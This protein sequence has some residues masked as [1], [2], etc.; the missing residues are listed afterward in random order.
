M[1]NLNQVNISEEKTDKVQKSKFKSTKKIPPSKP[2]SASITKISRL[3][4]DAS[5]QFSARQ[6]NFITNSRYDTTHT[7][8]LMSPIEAQRKNARLY[9]S[10]DNIALRKKRRPTRHLSIKSSPIVPTAPKDAVTIKKN[11]LVTQARL[12]IEQLDKPIIIATLLMCFLGLIFINSATHSFE[13]VRFVLIQSA[14]CILG[15][16]LMTV[17]SYIDYRQIIKHYRTIIAINAA[18]LLLT[19]IF[20]SSVTETSNANWIDLGIIKIQPSEFSKLLFIYTFSVHISYVKERLNKFST[21]ITLFIHACLIF[22]LVLLQK[23]LGSLTIFLMIF[24]AM[25]FASGLSIWYYILGGTLA[26]GLSPFIWERLST[27]Q[28]D[29]ILLCF[30]KS[31]D[32]NGTGIRYQQLRSS[33]AIG[34]GGIHGTGYMQGSLT[35]SQG[36]SLPAKHTDMI[37]STVCEEWG[38]IGAII[39][40]ALACYL[41]WRIV[42]LALNCEH[43]AGQ[44]ICVGVAWM[45][46][47]QIIENVGMCLGLMPVIGITFPFLSYGGSS[48]LSSFIAI[49]MVLS[50]SAHKESTFFHQGRKL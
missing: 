19:F 26:T 4:D 2:K 1:E 38:F 31:I 22:G 44:L 23:D 16:G 45:L 13:S 24:V 6:I 42:R 3:S 33:I 37:F 9:G 41:I 35:Q 46:I 21:F 34:N 11:W 28:K 8:R 40:L 43:H 18:M 29:R 15:F 36:S 5:A 32:P 25:C 17:I 7:S 30:D 48:A 10:T 14:A 39:V 50:V 12:H 49:G 27:Y 20:G 47:T